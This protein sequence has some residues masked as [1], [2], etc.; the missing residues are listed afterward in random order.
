MSIDENDYLDRFQHRALG[1]E[2][3]DHRGHLRM[4]WVHLRYYGLK[5]ASARV[6]EGVKELAAAFGAPEKYSH[7]LTEAFM[8]II[9]PRMR[10]EAAFDFDQFLADNPDLVSNAEG[11]VLRHYSRERLNSPEARKGWIEPDLSPFD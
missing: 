11:V 4:A 2:H 10:G 6:C 5:E 1:P 3:F 7:T 9:F 8:R